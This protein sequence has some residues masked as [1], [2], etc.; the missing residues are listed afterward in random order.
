M[1]SRSDLKN[2]QVGL[3]KSEKRGGPSLRKMAAII[4]VS[5]TTVYR[6]SLA[7]RGQEDPL[8]VVGRDG[9]CY[10]A[11]RDARL[12]RVAMALKALNEGKDVDEVAAAFGV[13]RRTLR[14]WRAAWV[15][16]SIEISS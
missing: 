5:S 9:K 14:R 6:D 15:L 4:G 1:K 8:N 3:A 11:S 16:R 12:R 10:A 13:S 7:T 2:A